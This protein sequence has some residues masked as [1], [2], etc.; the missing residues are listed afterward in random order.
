MVPTSRP[1]VHVHVRPTNLIIVR[2]MDCAGASTSSRPILRIN[3]RVC[4]HCNQIVS[5]KTY[6]AHKR[7]FYDIESAKW[8]CTVNSCESSPSSSVD[9]LNDEAPPTSFGSSNCPMDIEHDP[10]SNVYHHDGE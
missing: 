10:P 6:K 9:I 5:L 8:I 4:P 3:R 1:Y 2:E 7:L